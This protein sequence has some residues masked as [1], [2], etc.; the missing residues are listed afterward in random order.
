[1]RV[2]D[3]TDPSPAATTL[4]P[5]V[6]GPDGPA[7]DAPTD[8]DTASTPADDPVRPTGSIGRSVLSW[9]ITIAV[10][11]ALTMVVKA[12]V[13]QAY[14]IPSESMVPTLEIGDRVLVSK[15]DR[16][17]ERGDVVVFRRP[18]NDPKTSPDDPDVLI[19]RVI[20]LPGEQVSSDEEGHVLVDG[21]VLEEPYLPSGTSTTVGSPIAVPDGRLLVLGDNRGRSQDGRYFGTI[22]EDLLV[23]RAVLR[24][25]P[26]SR[27]GGI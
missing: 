23:G 3:P 15:L 14:S 4:G 13:F 10:A 25:W 24:I 1:M 21:R 11:F 20:G 19:K 5:E 6:P 27:A 9:A 12:W 26:P 18:A 16:E 7:P 8:V 17:P 22:S 2:T